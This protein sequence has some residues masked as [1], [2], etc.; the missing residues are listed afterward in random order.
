MQL[1]DKTVEKAKGSY[2]RSYTE[3]LA[4]YTILTHN[5]LAD[6]KACCTIDVQCELRS[7]VY[8]LFLVYLVLY[9]GLDFDRRSV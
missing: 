6:Y 4:N 9:R 5:F 2:L 8:L 7:R 1:F 3:V